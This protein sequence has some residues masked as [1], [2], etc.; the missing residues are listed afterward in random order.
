MTALGRRRIWFACLVILFTVPA[1]SILLRALA[2]SSTTQAAQ[3]WASSLSSADLTTASAQVEAYPFTYRK[4]IMTA[5]P[6]AQRAAVWQRH[7]QSYID[8]HGELSDEAV[9]LLRS[10]IALITPDAVSGGTSANRDVSTAAA[11]IQALLGRDAADYLLYR[12]GPKDAQTVSALPIREQLANFVRQQFSAIASI[13]DCDCATSWGCDGANSC[14]GN[15]T[16]DPDNSWPMCGW[17][18]NDPCN[19]LCK[20]GISKES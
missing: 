5:L 11:Q 18:W 19:G 1:E 6:A 16:C 3:Q 9:T 4:A 14:D 10:T 2:A 7:V 20:G 12:L 8:A 15:A 13:D 17:L